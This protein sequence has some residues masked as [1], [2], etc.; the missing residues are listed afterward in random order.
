MRRS[1]A[2]TVLIGLLALFVILFA[3]GY[4]WVY[5]QIESGAPAL[6]GAAGMPG[7]TATSA[8]PYGAPAGMPS[9]GT[10]GTAA[11]VGPTAGAPATPSTAGPPR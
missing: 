8:E 6:P 2:E 9:A 11:T 1:S 4:A 10:A 3:A 7:A 5:M